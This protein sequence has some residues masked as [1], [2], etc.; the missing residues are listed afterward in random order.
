MSDSPTEDR[1][2]KNRDIEGARRS[3]GQKG[4]DGGEQPRNG[5]TYTGEERRKG[6]RRIGE[7]RLADR[8]QPADTTTPGPYGKKPITDAEARERERSRFWYDFM[9]F[10]LT[11][12]SV[13]IPTLAGLAIGNWIDNRYP[14]GFSWA[15][16]LMA[17]GLLLG[18]L[19]AWY[20]IR[21][22]DSGGNK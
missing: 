12:W 3:H 17:I 22:H 2:D 15:L 16:T 14:A 13:V 20:W 11:G 4:N 21:H 6:E 7:R 8:R 10:N 18:C 1:P 9:R 19:N 5:A